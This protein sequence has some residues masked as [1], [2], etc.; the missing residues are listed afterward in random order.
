MTICISALGT[1]KTNGSEKKCIVMVTDHM[2]SI[3]LLGQFEKAIKKYKTINNKIVAML[4]GQTLLF[5]RCIEG[6]KNLNDFDLIKTQIYQ[7][8]VSVRKDVL[9]KELYNRY[10]INEDYVR[11][12]L[13]NP[14]QNDFVREILHVTN[15]T[16]LNTLIMLVGF[17]ANNNPRICEISEKGFVDVAD[18]DFHAIGSGQVQAINTLLFEKHHRGD[19]L[20]AT[21]YH[22]YK[23]KKNAEVAV[24]VGEE[25]EILILNG[26][27]IKEITQNDITLLDGIYKSEKLSAQ[28]HTNLNSLTF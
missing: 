21:V 11:A 17:D 23:A 22:A 16:A 27:E 8:M 7:N 9:Q 28:N 5:D 2:V 14:I 3:P 13:P 18:I 10:G 25:T 6:T 4:S 19:N 20:K 26:S 24:G 15:T 1:D 12:L